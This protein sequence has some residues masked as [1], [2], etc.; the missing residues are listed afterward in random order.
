MGISNIEQGILNDEGK[1]EVYFD[2]PCS[3][4]DIPHSLLAQVA[5]L[6]DALP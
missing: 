3:I 5:K 4:F 2:I 1:L 6:V